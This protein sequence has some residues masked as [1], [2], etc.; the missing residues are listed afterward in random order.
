MN[1]VMHSVYFPPEVGGLESHV[2][3]LCRSLVERGHQVSVVTSLSQPGL[4]QHELIDGINVWRTWL[5]IR[6]TLGWGAYAVCSTPRL[7]ALGQKADILHAQDIASV[8]PCVIAKR[9]RSTVSYTHLRAHE[10]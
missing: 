1:I 5:P 9:S 3:Y 10:T 7:M 2:R 8:L 4:A 6:N